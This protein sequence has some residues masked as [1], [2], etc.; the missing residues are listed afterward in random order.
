MGL[1]D[2]L[3]NDNGA[4]D[5]NIYIRPLDEVDLWLSDLSLCEIPFNQRR[6]VTANLSASLPTFTQKNIDRIRE[7]YHKDILWFENNFVSKKDS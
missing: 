2:F 5:P 6:N 4:I 7:F 3:V 1:L